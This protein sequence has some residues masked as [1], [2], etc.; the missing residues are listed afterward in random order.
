LKR[1]LPG[2][3]RG[4]FCATSCE[5]LV[6]LLFIWISVWLL[7]DVE[8]NM[9]TATATGT[10]TSLDSNPTTNGVTR[11]TGAN[12]SASRGKSQE[13]RIVDDATEQLRRS[14]R[15]KYRHVEA[16]HSESRPS[17]L[18][19]DTTATPSFLGFRNLMVIMLGNELPLRVCLG[20]Q[21]LTA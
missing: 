10:G 13:D 12:T 19:H 11:R 2:T 9:S 18:S 20:S 15:R 1:G 14:F 16:V 5:S 7:A 8:L 17:C 21:L 4:V 6:Y 3:S